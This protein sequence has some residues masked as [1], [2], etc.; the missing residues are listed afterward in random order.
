MFP[1]FNLN[2]YNEWVFQIFKEVKHRIP[3]A[4][5]DNKEEW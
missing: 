3:Q 2:N 1:S 4:P 5:Q